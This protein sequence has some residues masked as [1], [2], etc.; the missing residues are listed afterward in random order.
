MPQSNISDQPLAPR[1]TSTSKV[2]TKLERAL[3]FT[4]KQ[5]LNMNFHNQW[6]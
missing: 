3:T 1:G 2:I 5:G 4:T 6:E